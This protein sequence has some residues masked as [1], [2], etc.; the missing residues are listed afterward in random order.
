MMKKTEKLT[1][2]EFKQMINLLN[3]YVSTDMD[4]WEMW[5]FNSS[6]CP[7]YISISMMR[8]PTASEEAYI[9][10]TKFIHTE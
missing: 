3:R 1:E 9:D 8:E 10:L 4:Q 5:K 6:R 7:I 2:E